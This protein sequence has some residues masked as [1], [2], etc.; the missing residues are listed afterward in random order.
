MYNVNGEKGWVYGDSDYIAFRTSTD[1]IFVPTHRLKEYGEKVCEGK[2][3]RNGIK[4]K[5][6]ECYIPYCR[7]GNKEVI[8]KCPTSDMIEMSSFIIDLE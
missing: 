6:K 1:I 5:P 4:N 2:D 7:D 3:T 8:F